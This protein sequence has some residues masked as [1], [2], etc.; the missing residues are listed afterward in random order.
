MDVLKYSRKEY[1]QNAKNQMQ[2]WEAD[3]EEIT[4]KSK[5]ILTPETEAEYSRQIKELSTMLMASKE[6]VEALLNSSSTTWENEKV[7][8]EKLWS[9]TALTF[10]K[11][12]R[13]LPD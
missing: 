8:F 5:M 7:N 1:E 13:N 9:H 4:N 12:K 11:V 3:L 2:Q 6:K 10:Y